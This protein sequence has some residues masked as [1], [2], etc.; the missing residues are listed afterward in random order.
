MPQWETRLDHSSWGRKA[1][2]STGE[3]SLLAPHGAAPP[4]AA[5]AQA[6]SGEGAALSSVL[7]PA[8]TFEVRDR[9]RQG[10]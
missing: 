6:E 8:L 5:Q 10:Q 9:D 7:S 1:H 3:P 4:G 2:S